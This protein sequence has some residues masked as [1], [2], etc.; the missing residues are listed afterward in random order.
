[1]RKFFFIY[2]W[3]NFRDIFR[4][5]V[6]FIFFLFRV[7]VVV[8]FYDDFWMIFDFSYFLKVK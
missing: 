8:V 4:F 2:N 3:W 6:E 7:W 5:I 1:M